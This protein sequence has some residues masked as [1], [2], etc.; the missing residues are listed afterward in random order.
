MRNKV[1]EKVVLIDK[2]VKE[3][4]DTIVDVVEELKDDRELLY[5]NI[6]FLLSE[7][8]FIVNKRRNKLLKPRKWNSKWSKKIIEIVKETAGKYGFTVVH[9]SIFG[10][11]ACKGEGRDIDVLVIL[12]EHT[13]PKKLEE[14]E[15]KIERE[16]NLRAFEHNLPPLN[17]L[18]LSGFMPLIQGGR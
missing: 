8:G 10:S 3:L 18:V 5:S 17:A 13:E 14:L 2:D 12:K 4:I 16:W 15:V 9:A 7:K 1:L 6:A 11:M